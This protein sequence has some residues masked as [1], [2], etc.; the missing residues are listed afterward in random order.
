MENPK[1]LGAPWHHQFGGLIGQDEAGKEGSE[2]CFLSEENAFSGLSGTSNDRHTGN[3]TGCEI[4]P[5][6]SFFTQAFK[7]SKVEASNCFP[8]LDPKQQFKPSL[9]L[10]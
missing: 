3:F 6:E 8:G 7:S 2:A 9:F 10:D 1:D 5:Y 4:P